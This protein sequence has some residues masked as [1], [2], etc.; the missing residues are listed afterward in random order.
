MAVAEAVIPRLE[1]PIVVLPI[2]STSL[3]GLTSSHWLATD[4]MR[5]LE[6]TSASSGSEMTLI[7]IS[8]KPIKGLEICTPKSIT[9]ASVVPR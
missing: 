5:G 3:I 9:K 1:E 4:L 8:W 7:A 2:S 6:V